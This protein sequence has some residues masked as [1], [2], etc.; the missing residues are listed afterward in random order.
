MHEQFRRLPGS[1]AGVAAAACVL[2]LCLTALLRVPF[3][4]STGSHVE[5]RH[6]LRASNF[7]ELSFSNRNSSSP[8]LPFTPVT[9]RDGLEHVLVDHSN[10]LAYCSIAKNACTVWKRVMFTL[11]HPGE[12]LPSV[13]IH[14]WMANKEANLM[15]VPPAA[16]TAIMND[17]EYTRFVIIRD[18]LARFLSAFLNKCVQQAGNANCPVNAKW[19]QDRLKEVYGGRMSELSSRLDT[20]ETSELLD[21]VLA[22]LAVQTVHAMNVHFQPQYI[23]CELR[24]FRHLF[25]VIRFEHMKEDVEALIL[26][27]NERSPTMASTFRRA[28]NAYV[29]SGYKPNESG[30][31]HGLGASLLTPVRMA[32]LRRFLGDDYKFFGLP[33]P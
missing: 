21:E 23:H 4:V 14:T 18:P 13:D 11:L 1:K 25:Q 5:E 29:L 19:Y 15:D 27:I 30:A 9:V 8:R 24:I 32:K 10:K 12:A 2:T 22:K 20:N 28:V 6:P 17:P 31:R 7:A 3:L 33:L 26:R 16:A